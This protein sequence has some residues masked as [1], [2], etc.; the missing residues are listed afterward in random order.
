MLE[1]HRTNKYEQPYKGPYLVTQIKTNGTVHLNIGAVTDTVN[2]RHIHP[3]KMTSSNANH[4]GKCSMHHSIA[5]V[6]H[7][8]R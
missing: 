2:I 4:G 8:S 7:T 1:N 6:Q 3:F 5:Q